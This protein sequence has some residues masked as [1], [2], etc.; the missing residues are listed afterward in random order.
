MKLWTFIYG[1]GAISQVRADNAE[2]AIRDFATA[3]IFSQLLALANGTADAESVDHVSP[4]L[5]E[6]AS[7]P[8]FALSCFPGVWTAQFA[9]GPSVETIICVETVQGAQQAAEPDAGK[10]SSASREE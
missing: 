8:V 5:V 3:P 9:F 4:I 10:T 6:R 7:V 1:E 2:K